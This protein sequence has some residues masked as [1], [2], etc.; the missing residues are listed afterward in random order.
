MGGG[1]KRDFD[2]PGGGAGGGGGGSYDD[3]DSK[4]MRY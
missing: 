4:R 3:R 2:A 1:F